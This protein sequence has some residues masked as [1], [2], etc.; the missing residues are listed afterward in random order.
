MKTEPVFDIGRFPPGASFSHLLPS[1]P[2]KHPCVFPA[3]PCY[4][5]VVPVCCVF[6]CEVF[7][8][9]HIVSFVLYFIEL[10]YISGEQKTNKL[11]RLNRFLFQTTL[12][13]VTD[14][15]FQWLVKS[16]CIP[17]LTELLYGLYL[18]N[19]NCCLPKNLSE[20]FLK[21]VFKSIAIFTVN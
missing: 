2:P 19:R 10:E 16:L 6:T 4:E 8:I 9:L 15:T 3:A 5:T 20:N 14:T 1:H 12:Q 18:R 11:I 7:D 13:H 17:C 21:N